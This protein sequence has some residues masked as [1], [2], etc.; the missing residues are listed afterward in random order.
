MR[1]QYEYQWQV[2]KNFGGSCGL[3]QGTMAVFVQRI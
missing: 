1:W 2:G 3:F